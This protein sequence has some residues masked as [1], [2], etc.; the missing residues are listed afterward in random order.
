MK[1]HG[2]Y[3]EG[4]GIF[5]ETEFPSLSPKV[6]IVKG[7]NE[8]GKTTLLAFLRRMIFG[9]PRKKKGLNLYEPLNGGVMGGRLHIESEEQ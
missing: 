3:I 1:I 2:F 6:T 4:F 7:P 9:F 5:N 8:S